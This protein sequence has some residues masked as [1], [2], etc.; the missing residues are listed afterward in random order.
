MLY[1]SSTRMSMSIRWLG[2]YSDIFSVTGHYL[3]HWLSFERSQQQLQL[4]RIFHV[5]WFRRASD[6]SFL[7][8]GYSE[9]LRVLDWIIQR[10][11]R[12]DYE[13]S[14]S[15]A[16]LSAA[17]ALPPRA[18]DE[19]VVRTP[20]G[21]VP[22]ANAINTQGLPDSV[23]WNQLLHVDNDWWLKESRTVCCSLH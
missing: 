14:G 9:N 13:T 17:S 1:C 10:I 6:G 20:I 21:L 5:N 15:T 12:A 19:L 8:P 2:V 4:P 22:R 11:E 23:D 7:W 3:A 16:R 18:G